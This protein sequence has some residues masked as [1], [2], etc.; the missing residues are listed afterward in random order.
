M[1]AVLVTGGTGKTGSAL[2]RLLR[3]RGVMAR[4]ACRKPPAGDPDAVAFDWTDPATHARALEGVDRVFL[5][6]PV[7]SVDP[8]PV[9]APFLA[10]AERRGVRRVVLLGTAI[11]LPNS[12]ELAAEVRARPGWVVLR[13]SGFMQNFLSP[14][15]LGERIRRDGEIRTS[16]G[17]GRIGWID[18]RDIASTAAVLLSCSDIDPAEPRDHLLTGPKALSYPDAAAIIS[19]H[20]GRPVRV[21]HADSR[22]LSAHYQAAGVPAAFA[23]A[24]V[25]VEARVRAG[26]EDQ[27]T[28]TVLDLT[29]HAP[30][31]FAE[32]AQEHAGA[33]LAG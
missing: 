30:R 3:E 23:E 4:V 2:V 15:P 31:S 32:F 21:V 7:N 5:V 13:P 28:T 1:S 17:E 29:G 8:V 18:A 20:T 19:A 11:V 22:E 16:A 27:V 26:R 25:A 24:L 12:Q 14:H 9:V 6:P 33:W 10:E